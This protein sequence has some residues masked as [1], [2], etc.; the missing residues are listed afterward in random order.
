M[1]TLFEMPN[2][3]DRSAEISDCGKYRWWLR[4][5]W[6]LWSP[7]GLRIQGKG[8]CCFLMLNPSTADA[9]QDDPTI[10]RCIGFAKSWGY[11]TLSVR[12]IFPWRATDPKELLHATEPTGGRRGDIEVLASATADLLVAAWGS[13]VP[14]NRDVRVLGLLEEHF[15][16]TPIFC[17]KKSKEGNP[18]H[19]LYVKTDTQP[20]RF[21]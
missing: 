17:L 3:I 6:Q 1:K 8:V 7:D 18:W 12:N 15:P 11:G 20:L 21:R 14:F 16:A 2:R 13:K 4:R 5:S 9:T 10:R 19:P